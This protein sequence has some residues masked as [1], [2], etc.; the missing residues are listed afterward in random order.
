[1]KNLVANEQLTLDSR[2]VAE[3]VGKPHNDLIKSI[4]NSAEYL[5]EGNFSLS[6]FFIKSS[7]QDCTGRTLPCYLITRK[8]CEFIAHKMTGRKGAQ[9]TAE[10]INRFHEMENRLQNNPSPKKKLENKRL[11]RNEYTIIM[12][13]IRVPL[14][15]DIIDD[16]QIYQ[17]YNNVESVIK[18]NT[19]YINTLY[20]PAPKPK[21][22][23]QIIAKYYRGIPVVTVQDI[24]TLSGLSET[25]VRY[26]LK[27]LQ[28]G[29]DCFVVKGTDLLRFKQDN[30]CLNRVMNSITAITKS[31][32]KKL[33][34]CV[35]GVS[36]ELPGLPNKPENDT[37]KDPL[38]KRMAEMWANLNELQKA[39]ACG[40]MNRMM[41]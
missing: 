13:S 36:G 30:P 24:V 27:K 22:P 5:A 17:P 16:L 25:T 12:D 33:A 37:G 32:F 10:Y 6:E 1:M 8:G 15:Q 14:T 4:R 29:T 31:G 20:A 7:Y 34:K 19:R 38:T 28:E 2:E 35:V 21:E 41:A 3:M 11:G 39:E 26:H 23:P 9:F 18:D 40:Y